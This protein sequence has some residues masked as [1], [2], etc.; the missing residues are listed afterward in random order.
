M[1]NIKMDYNG[2]N[3]NC[4]FDDGVCMLSGYSGT[5]K[6]LLMKAI[7]FYCVNN[8]IKCRYCD[9]RY[10][11]MTEQQ[12]ENA[13]LGADVLILDNADLYLNNKLLEKLKKNA[14]QI[15]I[16]MKDT[17]TIDMSNITEYLVNYSNL[18][19][20]IEVL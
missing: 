12:I 10:K 5:G 17:T 18:S 19:L 13:C 8:S 16:C 15:I 20:T 2:I 11:D 4:H 1:L 7:E 6:T 14:Q 3:I 9:F